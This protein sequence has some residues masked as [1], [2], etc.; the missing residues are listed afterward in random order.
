MIFLAHDKVRDVAA[1][2]ARDIEGATVVPGETPEGIPLR[3]KAPSSLAVACADDAIAK[4]LSATLHAKV[5]LAMSYPGALGGELSVFDDGKLVRRII[6]SEDGIGI[7]GEPTSGTP[8]P[9]EDDVFDLDEDDDDDTHRAI[10][11]STVDDFCRHLGIVIEPFVP[12]QWTVLLTPPK[13]APRKQR[14]PGKKPAA[15]NRSA[16]KPRN[17]R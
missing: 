12:A 15:K 2:I 11:E 13:P 17:K 3:W 1:L 10:S 8:F 5:V 14:A 16:T 6:D 7:D 9:F 4:R